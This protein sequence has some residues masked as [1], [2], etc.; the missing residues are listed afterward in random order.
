MRG[1]EGGRRD[2]ANTSMC[3]RK[4]KQSQP[5]PGPFRDVPSLLFRPEV[6]PRQHRLEDYGRQMCKIVVGVGKYCFYG[7][8]SAFDGRPTAADSTPGPDVWP[9]VAATTPRRR[10]R[11][12][13]RSDAMRSTL[14]RFPVDP[15][16][17]AKALVSRPGPSLTAGLAIQASLGPGCSNAIAAH[18]APARRA[19]GCP[20]H[21]A[22]RAGNASASDSTRTKAS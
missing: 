19:A 3:L 8:L 13:P 20:P 14:P 11:R 18:F 10:A 5:P 4:Q 12:G 6:G 22:A 7:P 21:S 9:S 15:P 2:M 1:C 16:T 17:L